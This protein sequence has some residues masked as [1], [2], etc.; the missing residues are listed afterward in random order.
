MRLKA[1]VV[2]GMMAALPA[3][4][5]GTINFAT[6]P[7]ATGTPEGGKVYIDTIG[8]TPAEGTAY[9]A[10]LYADNAGTMTAVGA[11]VNFRTGGAAGY[12][13]ASQVVVPW[14]APGTEAAV[15]VRAWDAASGNSYE[16]A[17]GANGVVGVSALL[18]NVGPLGG[19]PVGGLPITD[20]NLVGLTPFTIT[21]VP[22]PSTLA[23]LALGAAGLML[24]R[25]KQ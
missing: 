12:V 17:L 15:E 16:A 21:Q 18:P 9:W 2:I 11:P 19:T 25:R 8:G 6:T 23:L 14:A 5:Q 4:G 13:T 7:A 22:E 24:R 3:F 1:L 20:P 10:Q